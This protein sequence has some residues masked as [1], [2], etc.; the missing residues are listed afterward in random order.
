M[1]IP[2]FRKDCFFLIALLL[3]TAGCEKQKSGIAA[4]PPPVS[5]PAS[6][7]A[8]ADLTMPNVILGRWKK[9]GGK[10][11]HVFESPTLHYWT[12][13][14]DRNDHRI[15]LQEKNGS[16]YIYW[17]DIERPPEK[18]EITRENGRVMLRT[19]PTSRGGLFGGFSEETFVRM[20]N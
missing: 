2:H 5:A 3:V 17:A 11:W 7:A 14:K 19:I 18:V 9:Q 16:W 13:G 6:P 15:S 4:P 10:G 8:V 1:K 12:D 20:E